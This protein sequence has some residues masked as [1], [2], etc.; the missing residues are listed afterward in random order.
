MSALPAETEPETDRGWGIGVETGERVTQ[1][2]ERARRD[3]GLLEEFVPVGGPF[4]RIDTHAYSGMRVTPFYDPLLAKVIVWAADRGQA[5]ARMTRALKEFR[6]SGSGVHTTIGFL[7][8]VLAHPLFRDGKHTTSL[9]EEML[10]PT[11]EPT[12]FFSAMSQPPEAGY[13]EHGSSERNESWTSRRK[14]W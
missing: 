6:V 5:L 12:G 10:T 7:R 2:A 9:M 4:T 1:A 11:R 13:T 8:E 3:P 14:C